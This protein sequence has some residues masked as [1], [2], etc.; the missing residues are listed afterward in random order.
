MPGSGSLPG[1]PRTRMPSSGNHGRT[2]IAVSDRQQVQGAT[3]RK[4]YGVTP[5][6]GVSLECRMASPSIHFFAGT[7]VN[8]TSDISSALPDRL[9][10]DGIALRNASMRCVFFIDTK[11]SL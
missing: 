3:P 11:E 10:R 4:K 6:L 1:G 7:I 8:T 5:K 2:K 9:F